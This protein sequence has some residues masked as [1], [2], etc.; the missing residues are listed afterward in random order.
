[1][2]HLTW[3]K[4]ARKA[5]GKSSQSIPVILER[6][7]KSHDIVPADVSGPDL[8]SMIT[9]TAAAWKKVES[10]FDSKNTLRLVATLETKTDSFAF[11]ALKGSKQP[12]YVTVIATDIVEM[13]PE[14]SN[15]RWDEG[16]GK[17]YSTT[18]LPKRVSNVP[19]FDH[20]R[21]A[22]RCLFQLNFASYVVATDEFKQAIEKAKLKGIRFRPFEYVS[23][24]PVGPPPPKTMLLPIGSYPASAAKKGWSKAVGKEWERLWNYS[25]DADKNRSFPAKAFKKKAPVTKAKLDAFEKKHGVKLPKSFRNVLQ[26]YSASVTVDHGWPDESVRRAH[27]S[28]WDRAIGSFMY[29]GEQKLW[30]FAE[31]KGFESFAEYLED[32]KELDPA[33]VSAIPFL[34]VKNG[35][36]IA[37]DAKSEEVWYWSTGGGDDFRLATDMVEFVTRWSWLAVPSIDYLADTPF[38]DRKKKALSATSSPAIKR[39]HKWLQGHSVGK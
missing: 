10:L 34:T 17:F 23:S 13:I 1:M 18:K 24:E 35:D 15:M 5:V 25:T 32:V 31:M 27:E 6:H 38:Y 8:S 20:N 2:N 36:V 30:D 14:H 26:D 11:T 7:G 21:I 33:K 19:V 9:F 39:W 29:F 3:T 22:G 28:D 37:V 4:N 16:K 12:S